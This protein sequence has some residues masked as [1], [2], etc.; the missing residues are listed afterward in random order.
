MKKIELGITSFVELTTN[1]KTYDERIHE[2]LKEIKHADDL[3]L[4]FFGIG[5]HH[6]KDYAASSPITILSAAAS[7]TKNIK[8][9]DGN[10]ERKKGS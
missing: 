9:G 6:R 2:V 10:Y 1:Y 7:I 3:G 5:E 8:L 4:D